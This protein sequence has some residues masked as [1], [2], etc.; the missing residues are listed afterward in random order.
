MRDAKLGR[1][2]GADPKDF[3]SNSKKNL[4]PRKKGG[5]SDRDS[6]EKRTLSDSTYIARE[7]SQKNKT[8]RK[9]SLG[10]RP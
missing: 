7:G 3:F 9:D 2:N 5:H 6:V 1:R 10:Q 8:T 4:D